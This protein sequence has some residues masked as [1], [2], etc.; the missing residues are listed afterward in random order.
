MVKL[1]TTLRMNILK[2]IVRSW[3]NALIEIGKKKTIEKN[4]NI[5]YKFSVRQ[6]TLSVYMMASIMRKQK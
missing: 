4:A 3:Q 2:I 5:N 6:H 1:M